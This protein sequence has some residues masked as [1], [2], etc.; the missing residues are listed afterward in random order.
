MTR[1]APIF[2]ATPER[3]STVT[4]PVRF[5]GTAI[6]TEA[7]LVLEAWSANRRLVRR[8]ITASAGAPERG[9]WDTTVALPPGPVNVILYEPSLENG[10]RLHTTE[11]SLT[12]KP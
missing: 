10:T 9:R 1:D 5:A 11:L 6:A 2:V 7:T 3:D 4:S 8:T 12:V